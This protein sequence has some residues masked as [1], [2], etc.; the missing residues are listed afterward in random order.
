MGKAFYPDEYVTSAYHIDYDALYDEGYRGIIYDVDNTLVFP[1]APADERSRKLIRRLMEKGYGVI[2][3]SNNKGARV[4][5]FAEELGVPYVAK[6]SKPLKKG[7]REAMRRMGTNSRNTLCIGDQLYT[8]ILGANR[9]GIRT[10]LTKPF[11]FEEEP[12]IILKRKLEVPVLHLF[13]KKQKEKQW[14]S[15]CLPEERTYVE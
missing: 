3:V 13:L 2:L 6:A 10:F 7:Y 14:E 8:D 5:T 1:D 15:V 4:R 9:L 11:T 12:Q